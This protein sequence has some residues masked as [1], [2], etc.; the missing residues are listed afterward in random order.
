MP[1]TG[2]SGRWS[3]RPW[4]CGARPS[5]LLHHAHLQNIARALAVL[6]R[7]ASSSRGRR[8]RPYSSRPAGERS[9]PPH[10]PV[11]ANQAAASQLERGLLEE[12]AQLKGG[13]TAALEQRA[14]LD[15]RL[16]QTAAELQQAGLLLPSGVPLCMLSASPATVWVYWELRMRQAHVAMG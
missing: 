9:R 6:A 7:V 16:Q 8:G 3:G 14:E 1:R 2:S 15:A 5:C 4:R 13:L 10:T 12:K 11:Q